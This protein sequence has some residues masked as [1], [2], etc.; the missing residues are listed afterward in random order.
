M[1]ERGSR[2]Y[3]RWLFDHGSKGLGADNVS[4]NDEIVGY[5]IV[6]NDTLR[7]EERSQVDRQQ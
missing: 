2:A 7:L 4:L 6:D 1:R 5:P 3:L